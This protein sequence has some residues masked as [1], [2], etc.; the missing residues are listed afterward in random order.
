MNEYTNITILAPTQREAA[1]VTAAA[2]GHGAGVV[3]SGMGAAQTAATLTALHSAG[4]L[5]GPV[6]LAGI[7]GAYP[8]GGLRPGDCAAALSETMASLGAVRDGKF[9][10]LYQKRYCCPWAENIKSVS[11]AHFSTVDCVN[12][13]MSGEES[14][15]VENMEGASFYAVMSALGL[16]FLEV[17]AVSNF[18][19]DSRDQWQ[20]PLALGT[21]GDR[22]GEV[23]EELKKS[24][25]ED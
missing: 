2:E 3:I 10:P 4:R 5:G 12:G 7:G 13:H 11:R 18:T 17:R 16:P 20:I 19:T 15:A 22:L 9:V 23:I 21:L 6:I 14:F 1:A 8:G 25:H 24:I